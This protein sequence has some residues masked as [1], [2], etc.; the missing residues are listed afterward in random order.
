MKT[1]IIILTYNQIEYTK[2]CIE[3]IRDYTDKK[4]YELIVVDNCSTD[5]TVEWLQKQTDIIVIYNSENVGFPKG[6]NQGIKIA[7]GENILLLNNDT[8]VTSNWLENLIKCLYSTQTIGAVGP[9]TNSAAYYTSISVD[10]STNEEMQKFAKQHNISNSEKWEERLKL[11]GFCLLIKREVI[12]NVGLLDESFSPG[13]YEDD[14]YCLRMRESN[15][16]LMLCKDTFIHHYGS[17]SWK[18]E[19]EG[20]SKLLSDNHQKFTDKWGIDPYSFRINTELIELIHI[21]KETEFSILHIG[22]ESG[23]TL[24]QLRNIYKKAQLYGLEKNPILARQAN[25]N[26][27]VITADFEVDDLPFEENFFD[28][29]LYTSLDKSVKPEYSLRRV[30]KYLKT[31]GVFLSELPNLSHFSNIR[32]LIYGRNSYGNEQNFY[33]LS[34]VDSLFRDSGYCFEVKG[35][36]SD[37]TDDDKRFIQGL[38]SLSHEDL[39][40]QFESY[41]FLIKASL[42][43]YKIEEIFNRGHSDFEDD[44]IIELQ[45]YSVDEVIDFIIKENDSNIKLLNKIAISNYNN[46]YH[47]S[48]LPYLQAAINIDSNDSDTLYNLAF[49]LFS[50]GEKELA[51]RYLERI[52]DKDSEVMELEQEINGKAK[53]YLELKLLIRR[54]EYGIEKEECEIRL[55]NGL[56]EHIYCEQDIIEVINNDII[57]KQEVLNMLA[58]L[59]YENKL[60][61]LIFPFLN[62]SYEINKNDNDTLFNLGFLLSQFGEY[63]LAISFLLQINNKDLEVLQLLSHLEGVRIS[64]DQ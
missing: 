9:V 46:N 2:R 25:F 63:E 24:L 62:Q 20:F 53:K 64:H 19:Y 29:I 61:D 37:V 60:F 26:A 18:K 23:G 54:L 39:I 30:K 33:T 56:T 16:K 59:C 51:A 43:K 4:T 50:Y 11:I 5:G 38:I 45:K 40:V 7:N 12:E 34:D 15:Y 44:Y 32:N 41:K 22:C 31:N 47:E 13:N 48:V 42:T 14:D 10:Y 57:G 3:S 55:I 6:C 17:V 49:I 52:K 21:P 35:L 27:E 28:V 8:V 36:K 58:I 1:S